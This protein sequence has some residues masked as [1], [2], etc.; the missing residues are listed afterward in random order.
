MSQFDYS[1][2]LERIDYRG[3]G[4]SRPECIL[5]QHN[6]VL[7]ISDDKSGVL[8]LSP[9]GAQ[10]RIG[11]VGGAPNGIAM[12]KDGS[13]VIANIDLCSIQRL[14]R[15]G[16]S[17]TVVD[18]LDGKP[19]G[20]VNFVLFDS[21]WRLWVSVSTLANPRRLA[22]EEP[23]PDGYVMLIEDNRARVVADGF[24]FTNEIRFNTD[25]TVLYVAETARGRITAFDVARSGELS[26]RR[27]FG[28]DGLWPGALVDGVTVD[29]EDVLWVTE[30]TRNGLIAIPPSQEPVVVALDPGGER[31]SFPT[32]VTFG[33][34]D[35]REVYVGSLKMDRL[36]HFR[37]DVPG[38]RPVHWML[39]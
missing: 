36:V 11:Q 9:D 21:A 1:V 6:G 15:S 5:A 38:V 37:A 35:L 39:E 19:L 34:S 2:S 32:S 17:R 28:P 16:A 18:E 20:A 23:R 29:S 4:L 13:F 30:I 8:K 12:D 25:E 31:M 7:W 27:I 10:T 33:G 3:T 26:N 24:Y 14:Q 22:I